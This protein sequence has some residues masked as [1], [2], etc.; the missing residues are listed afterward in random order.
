MELFLIRTK[1]K[2]LD[3]GLRGILPV[4][5]EIDK[6]GRILYYYENNQEFGR[7]LKQVDDEYKKRKENEC[8]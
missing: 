2:A 5:Q 8:P 6:D 7:I 4:K 1:G 3:L